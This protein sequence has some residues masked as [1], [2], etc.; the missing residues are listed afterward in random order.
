[1]KPIPK[2]NPNAQGGEKV[3]VLEDMDLSM[4]VPIIKHGGR[5]Y[6]SVRVRDLAFWDIQPGDIVLMKLTKVRRLP[7]PIFR[8]QE[9]EG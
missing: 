4:A 6:L 1:M 3:A 5:F 7:R 9:G 2:P 8:G